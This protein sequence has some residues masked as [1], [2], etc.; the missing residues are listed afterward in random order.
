MS[1]L[2]IKMLVADRCRELGLSDVQLAQALGYRNQAKGL[3]RLQELQDG[4]FD[5]AGH[6][7]AKLPKALQL[8]PETILAAVQATTE[9][10]RQ[11]EQEATG[12]LSG[13]S[14]RSIQST[15]D[16]LR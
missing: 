9:L 7:L 2:P 16:R 3:R 15:V 8:P 6:I 5:N 11:R 1:Q 14:P 12:A 10:L 13:H 4:H